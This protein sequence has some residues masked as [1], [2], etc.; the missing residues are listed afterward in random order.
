MLCQRCKGN[1]AFLLNAFFFICNC[2][3]ASVTPG[4]AAISSGVCSR[5]MSLPMSRKVWGVFVFCFVLFCL[6]RVLLAA[7]A[8]PALLHLCVRII[9]CTHHAIP[10]AWTEAG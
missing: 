3:A 8:R 5:T 7:S 4:S 10:V 9:T 1:L 2:A 6:G